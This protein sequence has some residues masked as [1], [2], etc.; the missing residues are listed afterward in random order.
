MLF[1]NSIHYP[2]N[3]IDNYKKA[4]CYE[5]SNALCEN[6]ILFI[7]IIIHIVDTITFFHDAFLFTIFTIVTI[8]NYFIIIYTK[9]IDLFYNIIFLRETESNTSVLLRV[10]KTTN[11][12]SIF[13]VSMTNRYCH[14]SYRDL[15]WFFIMILYTIVIN[16]IFLYNNLYNNLIN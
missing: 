12:K 5:I 8:I 2:E 13:W 3:Y 14:L 16:N 7:W 1:R 9:Q 10:R 4:Y 15:Y 11:V 6:I